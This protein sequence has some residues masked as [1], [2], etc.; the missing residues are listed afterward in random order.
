MISIQLRIKLY[1]LV[2]AVT[3]AF[4]VY[5]IATIL[6]CVAKCVYQHEWSARAWLLNVA[7]S[8]L[9]NVSMSFFIQHP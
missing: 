2:T 1:L 5:A 7:F 3:I 6:M 8:E 4:F 9:E